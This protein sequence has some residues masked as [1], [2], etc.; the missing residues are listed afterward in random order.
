MTVLEEMAQRL[1]DTFGE[2]PQLVGEVDG[3]EDDFGDLLLEVADY[4]GVDFEDDPDWQRFQ[5]IATKAE[6]LTMLTWILNIRDR[7]EEVDSGG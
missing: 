5:D 2:N 1:S 3:T 7:L 4:F 6:G